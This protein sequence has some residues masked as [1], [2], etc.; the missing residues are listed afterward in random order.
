MMNP[1][2][3]VPNER[4]RRARLLKGWSQA[5]LAEQVGTSFEMVSRWER[6]VTVPSP[7]YRKR[8]YAVLGKTAEEL[9]L[10]RD[11]LDPFTPPTSP[12]LLLAS[13][14]A[15]AEKAIVSHLKTTLQ[16]RG[17]A[18]WS[19]RQFGRQGTESS[20]A[21]LHEVV[22]AAQVILV[23]VSPEARSSRYVRD[24]FEMARLYQRPVCGIWIEGEHLEHCL[25][26]GHIELAALIDARERDA[27]AMLEETA[28]ALEQVRLASQNGTEVAQPSLPDLPRE[29]IPPASPPTEIYVSTHLSEKPA[30]LV[31]PQSQVAEVLPSPGHS[32]EPTTTAKPM[33]SALPQPA[34]SPTPGNRMGLSRI[35]VAKQQKKIARSIAGFLI[36]LV[37]LLIG[38]ALLGS[39][40]LLSHLR[41]TTTIVSP[42]H[43]GTWTYDLPGDV[44]SLIPNG[45][46]DPTS[47]LMDQ[48][49]YLPL[50]YGDA[51]GVIHAEA[52]TEKPTIQNGG[53]SADATTWTFHLRPHLVWSDGAPY[54]A[55]DVDYT[56]QLWSNPKF[57][58]GST[59]GLNLISSTEVSADHLSITF[60]LKR[61]FAPFLANLWVDGIFAPLPA[62]HFSTMAPEQIL[63]SPDNLNPKVTSGP[64]MMAESV[65]GDHYTLVHNPGY[66]R[67]SEGLPYLDKVVFGA[68]SSLD[69]VLKQMQAGS[70][71]ATSLIPSVQNFQVMQRLKDY[72]LIYPPAQNIFEALYFNFH[73]PV[74]ASHLEVRQAMA[75]AVD[76]QTIIAGALKGL[77]TPLCTDHPSAYHPGFDPNAPCQLFELAAANKLLDDSGWVRGPDGVR[78]KDGQRLEFEYSSQVGLAERIDVETIIQRDFQ[79]IGIKLDIQNY[80]Y[81]T[82]FGTFLPQGKASPPTGAVA[83]RYDIAEWASSVGYDPDDSSLLSCDQI[84]PKGFGN[85]DFYCNPSLDKLFAQEQATADPGVRQQIFIQ[86][87]RIYLTQFPFIVLYGRTEFALAHKG[88]HNYLPGPYTDTYNVAEWWCDNGRC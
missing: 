45:A 82:F 59:L 72:M 56:W 28:K 77:G 24:A 48:V 70:L 46:N 19:I 32:L 69:L 30:D 47:P 11:L 49:L 54:D 25:P 37:I 13:S 67:S 14:H 41:T 44:R 8:L 65:P 5:E 53:V 62:H 27:P 6:G 17:I 88:T 15:D 3:L 22:R 29:A 40:L 85:L 63:K 31:P 12:L 68:V 87:H 21:V 52:A 51:Q 80:L 1:E 76:Q 84:P 66:Y 57:A 86:I 79:Q 71:D 64:F 26:E 16:R 18:L 83:G 43:G 61:P 74:L 4:L 81:D 50:F 2:E 9:G 73:Y 78:A 60:H 58:A 7:H 38:G 35:R 75:M 20:R 55:R 36:G 34:I 39:T 42:I 33:P 23:I 10:M